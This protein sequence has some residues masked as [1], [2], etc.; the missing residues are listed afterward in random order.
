M[1]KQWITVPTVNK[2]ART[3]NQISNERKPNPVQSSFWPPVEVAGCDSR[4]ACSLS[5]L[6]HRLNTTSLLLAGRRLPQ[7]THVRRSIAY[8]ALTVHQWTLHFRV[9]LFG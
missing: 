9:Q 7:L 8:A 1:C 2:N 4:I 6:F 3:K 5:Q